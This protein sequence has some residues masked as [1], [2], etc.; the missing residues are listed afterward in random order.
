M[1]TT[2][3][4]PK[5]EQRIAAMF[6]LIAPKYDLLNALLSFRQ[7]RRWRKLLARK[8][9]ERKGGTL[10]DCATG[11]GDVLLE[12][13]SQHKEYAHFVGA[14][15]S[16]QMLS[17]AENKAAARLLKKSKVSFKKFSAEQIDMPE[18]SCD[19][20]SISF[21]LRNVVDRDKALAE[22]ARVLKPGGR[23]LI[24]EFFEPDP[25]LWAKLFTF[26]FHHI[27]PKIGG[28]IS[29][30]KAY[31]YLPQSVGSFYH[32]DVLKKKLRK[33]GLSEV[34]ERTFLFGSC[35]LIWA[36]KDLD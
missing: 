10:L 3:Q 22:F 16:Q 7:D 19:A 8:V 13:Y 30:K 23:L 20:V 32:P 33:V 26:Y 18:S 31:T 29:D 11:T 5:S 28:L 15:I 17:I 2:I 1:S 24:L 9:P 25:G 12:C 14:D 21:G 4:S 36:D 6:D 34:R 35:R 27:L